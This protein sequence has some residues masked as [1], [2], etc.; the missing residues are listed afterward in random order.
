[1]LPRL[2]QREWI[3]NRQ[4]VAIM[5]AIYGAYQ[6]Y[7]LRSV[8]S[9]RPFVVMAALFAAFLT[10]ALFVREDKFRSAWWACTLPVT[11]LELIRARYLAAW[12][13][14]LAALAGS[15]LLAVVVPG[16]AVLVAEVFNPSTLLIAATGTTL[17]FAWV[18]PFTIRFGMFGLMVF[19]IG[20]Q[21]AGAGLLVLGRTLGRR[22][23]AGG[24]PIRTALAAIGDTVVAAREALTPGIF[25]VVVIVLLIVVN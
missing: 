21:V 20:A 5:F 18:L 7:V 8:D 11:R 17:I 22:T 2:L 6:V 12:S 4:N 19:L 14:V 15:T 3:L 23:G 16:S 10:S 9:T 1:M 13:M 24:R 25:A